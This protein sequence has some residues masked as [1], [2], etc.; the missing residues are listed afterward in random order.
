MAGGISTDFPMAHMFMWARALRLAD[1][2]DEVHIAAIAKAELQEHSSG[3]WRSK[4]LPETNQRS[5]GT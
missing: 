5:I 1:G 2:P 4:R 3:G